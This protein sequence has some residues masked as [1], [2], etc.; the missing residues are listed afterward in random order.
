[1]APSSTGAVAAGIRPTDLRCEY[2]VNPLGL[3]VMQPRLSWVLDAPAGGRE[4]GQSAWQVL[5]AGTP[6][7]L[8]RNQGD[9]W[10]SGKVHVR[11][12]SSDHVPWQAAGLAHDVLLEGS[13][14][15]KNGQ[16]STWSD[17]ASWSMG[18]LA[19]GDWQAEWIAETD[20]VEPPHVPRLPG[21]HAKEA[22][23]VDQTR[24]V[25]IDLART[26]PSRK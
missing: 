8:A 23:R 22:A 6:E 13:A 9:L 26:A 4:Q 25:Q 19:V 3:D 1:M 20:Q 16:P 24:W 21:Y 10:D 2:R 12:A 11:P 17:P 5:V 15:D 7:A 14:W 18:L